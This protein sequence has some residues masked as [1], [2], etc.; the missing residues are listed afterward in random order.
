MT[1]GSN[2]AQ[3]FGTTGIQ[4]LHIVEYLEWILGVATQVLNRILE[5]IATK[6]SSM[7][8]AV[9]LVAASVFLQGT[10]THDALT[11]D[12][13]GLALHGLC[14]LDGGT[15]LCSIVT[16]DFLH[17]PTQ[18]TILHGGVLVHDFLGF[19]RKLDVIRVIEHDEVVQSQC[20]CNAGS[21]L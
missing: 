9:A 11:D 4:F 12:E 6:G 16:I 2:L 1:L 21:A 7:C 15:N 8:L 14:L 18:R 17:V 13:C 10:L 5:G 3:L 19:G 20:A